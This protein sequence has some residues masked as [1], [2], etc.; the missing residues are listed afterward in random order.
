[1]VPAGTI[2]S[3]LLCYKMPAGELVQAIALT[4]IPRPLVLAGVHMYSTLFV[5][6]T[7]R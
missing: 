1:M 2:L 7:S 4:Y 3:P 5:S 6:M